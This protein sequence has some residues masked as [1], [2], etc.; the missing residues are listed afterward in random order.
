[1][2][3]LSVLILGLAV[4][5]DWEAPVPV[6]IAVVSVF[7]IFHGYAHGREYLK[8]EARDA[9]AVDS[10]SARACFTSPGIAVG[11]A[12]DFPRGTII[13]RAAGAM[14]ALAG[15]AYILMG[16]GVFA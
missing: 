15:C 1:M 4:A 8:P 3:A 9:Y 7:A 10:C 16:F 2:I 14:T 12:T 5:C 6:A 11:W 13:L